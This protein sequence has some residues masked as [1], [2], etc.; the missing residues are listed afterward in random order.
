MQD[1]TIWDTQFHLSSW[2][3]R[4]DQ[5]S[6][7]N[8]GLEDER[9]NC[10]QPWLNNSLMG[11]TIHQGSSPLVKVQRVWK[12]GRCVHYQKLTSYNCSDLCTMGIIYLA[13]VYFK[14]FKFTLNWV[15]EKKKG[16]HYVT[17]FHIFV[18]SEYRLVII[19]H[20]LVVFE[21]S[22]TA[23]ACIEINTFLH[24]TQLVAW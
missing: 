3:T 11:T 8:Y 14:F 4:W 23:P 24:R 19:V 12:F 2:K 1:A 21:R 13:S 5:K 16:K 6:T 18:L 15:V 10:C 17:F 20:R 22:I 9:D 7:S